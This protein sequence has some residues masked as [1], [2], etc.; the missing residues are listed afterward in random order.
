MQE[1]YPVVALQYEQIQN[2]NISLIAM[3]IKVCSNRE[4][5]RTGFLFYVAIKLG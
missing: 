1:E 3:S 2:F 4:L 5:S